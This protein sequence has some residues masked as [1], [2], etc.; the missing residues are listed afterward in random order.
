MPM[1]KTLLRSSLREI[2]QAPGR[3]LSILGIIFLGVA[4]FVGISATGP[5]M[6][7]AAED[8]FARQK[9]ADF[10]IASTLG[11]ST[12]D[13]E[14]IEE[15]PGVTSVEAEQIADI[16][17]ENHRAVIRVFSL[18]KER[19]VN[20]YQVTSGRLPQKSGEIA[21]DQ[22]AQSSGGFA[23]DETFELPESGENQLETHTYTIVGFVNSP[24][25]IENFHRGNSTVGNGTVDYFAVIPEE[26]FKET[27]YARL[28]VRFDELSQVASYSEAY[29]TKRDQVSDEVEERL[30][31]RAQGRRQELI[32]EAQPA[33]DEAKEQIRD[34][35]E[36]LQQAQAELDDATEKLA[37]AHQELTEQE[38][39]F[40]TEI[41]TAQEQLN[42]EAQKLA[43]GKQA[44][45]ENQRLLDQN[46]QALIQ[47]E[48]QVQSAQAQLA[49]VLAQRPELQ[50]GIQQVEE[51][52][53]LA[54]QGMDQI[55]SVG[56]LSAEEQMSQLPTVYA[57]ITA[58]LAQL[59]LPT[60][61][62]GPVPDL[63][64]I[65]E[66]MIA[67]MLT[68]AED[69]LRP[70]IAE[71]EQQRAQLLGQ[72]STINDQEAQLQQA[73]QQVNAGW[74]QIRA[75]R[76]ELAQAQTQITQGE[77]QLSDA[78][79]TLA[80]EK[81]K[82]QSLL[83][84]GWQEYRENEATLQEKVDE[85]K[86]RAP[87]EREKL[88]DAK[89]EVAEKEQEL[90][91]LKPAVY[92]VANRDA[93]P[94]YSEYQDNAERVSSLATI[95]PVIFFLIAALVSLTTMTRM[96]DEKRSE[97][98]TLKALGYRNWEIGQ[99]FLLYSSAA[100]ITGAVLGLAV[101]F[102]FFPAIIIQ[103]Y[104]PLYNLTEYD[105]PWYL[106]LSLIAVGVSL[107]C[108]IGIALLVLRFD[109]RQSSASLLRPKAPKTGKRIL[110]ERIT[111]IWRHLS[112]IQKVTMRNLFR[113][114]SRML[115]TILGIAGCTSMILT[116]FGLRDSISN[117]IP[118]QFE[119]IWQYQAVITFDDEDS[120]AMSETKAAAED[121][122]GFEAGLFLHTESLTLA[123]SGVTQQEV[124]VTV[125]EDPAALS[126]FVHLNDRVSGE[127]YE[128]EGEG[129][130]I[131]E[132]LA[133]L[134]GLSVGDMITLTNESG[135]A[136]ELNVAAIAEN[137]TG[138]FAYLT[139]DAYQKIFQ[140]APSYNSELLKFSQRLTKSEEEAIAA[141]LMAQD[142]VIN[143]SFLSASADALDDTTATLN[144]VIWILISSAG[145]LA[146]IVLYNLNNINIAERIRELSTIKVLG[147]YDREV[148]MYVFR[149]N[150]FL[151]IFGIAF[152]LLL[153]VLQHQFVLQTIEV[154]IAMFSPTVEPMSYVYAAGLTCLFS[155][156]VGIAM[157]FKLKH[158]NMIDALKANE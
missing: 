7:Q 119:K 86:E 15:M 67:T 3:F 103:A 98:G 28:L 151:T 125:P 29:Q 34:G 129:A 83:A 23:L 81:A 144:I 114:K 100:G 145:A 106:R 150:I 80:S 101:G 71:G 131:N 39:A 108:T 41:Q 19:Q 60:D 116:G 153:G 8:Y 112:F 48:A 113:Y 35:E 31:P 21:L 16:N 11:L 12:A 110:L 109:L 93:N 46:E 146:F 72:L 1:K 138:H 57:Q 53:A 2:R 128:L 40:Q 135:E 68:A 84:A 89:K 77:T 69:T 44:L 74:S 130:I 118:L 139:P 136:F 95:F 4:F 155:S 115:M 64:E 142:N 88:E 62:L 96:I 157:Y 22:A 73:Q 152:G 107:L 123:Q 154:D 17:A 70:L 147:F 18:S 78:R 99:K 148:T 102:S 79:E 91:D 65:D 10:T 90:L 9:L 59:N 37:Q 25:F 55:R 120:E 54:Y 13:R 121:I 58:A 97:I 143:V 117:I 6:E 26:D 127:A 141:D 32:D 149:E 158:V 122:E 133:K 156:V 85:F 42:G 45:I 105:T 137:Y 43:E 14:I 50:K 104:G 140:A 36:A 20:Q 38:A 52:L 24:E 47:Q 56:Q 75:G 126:R 51:Q 76:Q 124:T 49:P 87:K 134:F 94:G 82:G 63:E 66:T 30:A 61:V 33:I 132:K 111:V 27:A 5:N 92:R